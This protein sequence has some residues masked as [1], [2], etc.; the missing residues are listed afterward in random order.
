MRILVTHVT[1]MARGFCC[2]AGVTERE[3]CHVRPVIG[4]RLGTGLLAPAGP[5]DFGAIVDLGR[6]HAAG[7][8]PPE[9]ED[10]LFTPANAVR[11][12]YA[13][14]DRI[15]EILAATAKDSLY[16]IFGPEL[17]RHPGERASVGL[18][19][20]R[21]SLAVY[22]PMAG[23][24]LVTREAR[25]GAEHKSLRVRLPAEGL[26][27]SLTDA[28]Y[29]VSDFQEPHAERVASARRALEAGEEVLLGVGLTR[30]F[31]SSADFEERHWLQVNAVHFSS[32]PGL[33][34][35]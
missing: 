3:H 10:H 17:E 23:C 13:R 5:F 11:V 20:G 8:T 27:L 18:L 33:R 31:R 2:V 26:D 28:R 16:D 22:R 29:Y 12:G 35:A 19:R 21:C 24:E 7:H 15:W 32:D 14:A 25:D 4:G 30:P 1:R 6:T 34:L 9:V